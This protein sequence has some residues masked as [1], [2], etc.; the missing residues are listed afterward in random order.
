MKAYVVL[1]VLFSLS[2]AAIF[3][4]SSEFAFGSMKTSIEHIK[5]GKSYNTCD[6]NYDP[7]CGYGV[8]Y[9]GEADTATNTAEATETETEFK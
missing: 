3:G 5:Y 6:P 4:T 7:N 2:V 8:G 9:G 1:I